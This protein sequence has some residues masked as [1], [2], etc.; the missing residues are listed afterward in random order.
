M[1][2]GIK[3]VE[4]IRYAKEKG[5]DF[6]VCD[7]HMPDAE[8]PPAVA[9]LNP[10][11]HDCP[12]PYKELCGCGVGFKLITALCKHMQMP[13]EYY[14]RYLDLVV[15]AIAADIVPITGENRILAYFGLKRVN[16]HPSPGIKALC[17]FPNWNISS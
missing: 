10:K 5:I 6:I 12:Y 7:H 3:S 16:E 11:Q 9:I 4:L 13:D 8:L 14:L 17:S 2:C 1:D 15:T